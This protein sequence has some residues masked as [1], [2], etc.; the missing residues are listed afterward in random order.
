[1]SKKIRFG[2]S[3]RK[4]TCCEKIKSTLTK[5]NKKIKNNYFEIV[6]KSNMYIDTYY[7][8]TNNVF[9]VFLLSDQ[10][11]QILLLPLV[12]GNFSSVTDT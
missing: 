10:L 2:K 7:I 3:L 6:N 8:F 12:S 1:M 9:C 11:I 5:R 4:N